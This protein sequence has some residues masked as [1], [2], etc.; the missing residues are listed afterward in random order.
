MKGGLDGLLTVTIC[1]DDIS[2]WAHV[3]LLDLTGGDLVELELQDQEGKEDRYVDANDDHIIV[4][5]TRR[6]Q[7]KQVVYVLSQ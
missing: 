1:L 5:I 2:S 4:R 3:G 6:I 7:V